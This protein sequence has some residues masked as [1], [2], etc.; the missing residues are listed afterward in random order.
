[1]SVGADVDI[2]YIVDA[3]AAR[4]DVLTTSLYGMVLI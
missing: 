3:L 4:A 1:M 2:W